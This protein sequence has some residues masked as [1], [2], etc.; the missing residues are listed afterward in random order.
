MEWI[1]VVFA[2]VL[3]VKG[4]DAS[5]PLARRLVDAWAKRIEEGAANAPEPAE[6]AKLEEELHALK[7]DVRSLRDQQRFLE[8][9]LDDRQR[10]LLAGS[11]ERS[12]VSE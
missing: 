12:P 7:A 11:P 9:L 8:R 3:L 5:F 10:E 1:L 6:L 4:L 2:I